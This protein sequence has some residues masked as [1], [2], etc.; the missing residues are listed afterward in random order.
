VRAVSEFG[1]DVHCR[2]LDEALRRCVS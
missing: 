1:W 2:K